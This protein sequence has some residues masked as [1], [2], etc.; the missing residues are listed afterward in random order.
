[1]ALNTSWRVMNSSLGPAFSAPDPPRA[2]AAGRTAMPAIMAT[3]VSEMMMRREFLT[4]LSF[5]LR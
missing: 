3:R 2:K 4:K 5:L 1:M